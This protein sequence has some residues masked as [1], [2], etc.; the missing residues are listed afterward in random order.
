MEN[1]EPCPQT[2]AKVV[3]WNMKDDTSP[4][5]MDACVYGDGRCDKDEPFGIENV[6][7]F[8][9]DEKHGDGAPC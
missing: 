6:N 2:L 1:H 4:K 3:Q 8:L 7:I 5:G 9:W